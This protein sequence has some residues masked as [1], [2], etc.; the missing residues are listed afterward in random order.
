M[1]PFETFSK[2]LQGLKVTFC[3]GPCRSSRCSFSISA[4]KPGEES[5]MNSLAPQEKGGSPSPERSRL[6]AGRW[7]QMLPDDTGRDLLRARDADLSMA[8]GLKDQDVVTSARPLRRRKDELNHSSHADAF[9]RFC[10][11]SEADTRPTSAGQTL[12]RAYSREGQS[13][14]RCV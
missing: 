1:K 6:C 8:C 5:S 12:A 4:V 11:S 2:M 9:P 7:Y 10:G 13:S 3:G 14:W